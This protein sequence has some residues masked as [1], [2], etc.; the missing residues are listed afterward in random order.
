M[1]I[2]VGFSIVTNSIAALSISGVTVKDIDQIPTSASMLCPILFP[3][4]N[5]FVTGITP[6]FE[7][8]GSNGGA[9]INMTYTL[10]YVFLECEAGSGISAF[11]AYNGLITHIAAIL[12]AVLSNDAITGA[13]DIT[14]HGIPNI[15]V[16]EDPAGN[17][18]WGA[19]LSFE[20]LE[21]VQ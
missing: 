8:Y 10:N 5:D 13:V 17:Q 20:I 6:T 7:T 1:T 9:K 21:Y 19:L 2:T 14:P 12:Q 4:P 16:I 15:G 3:Q 11:D 18:F